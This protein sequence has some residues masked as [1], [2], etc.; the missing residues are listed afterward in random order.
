MLSLWLELVR[1]RSV[2]NAGLL[3]DGLDALLSVPRRTAGMTG[4]LWFR[5][6]CSE[7]ERAADALAPVWSRRGTQACVAT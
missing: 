4:A 6:P 2:I 3:N 7:P 5:T 1:S